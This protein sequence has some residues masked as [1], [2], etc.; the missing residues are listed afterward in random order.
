MR[1]PTFVYWKGMIKPRRSDGLFDLADLFNTTISLAGA[2]GAQAADYVPKAH[3]IDGIDQASFLLADQ[4]LSNRRSRIYTMNQHL[5]GFAST[6]S[7]PIL[8]WSCKRPYTRKASPG[9]SAGSS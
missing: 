8:F 3:Y 2:P 1:V 5:S 7:N 9:A 6:S 4:G